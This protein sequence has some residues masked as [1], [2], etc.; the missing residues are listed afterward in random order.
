MKLSYPVPLP[1][2]WPAAFLSGAAAL[3]YEIVWTR[4]LSL[5]MGSTT[6]AAA[7]VLSAFML[8]LAAG[9]VLV[10]S[11]ADSSRRPLRWYALLEIGIG[12]YAL[13]FPTLLD[14][15]GSSWLMGCALVALPAALMGATLPVLT[16]AA[17][18]TTERGTG[19]FGSLYGINTLGAVAGAALTTLVF[20]ETLG[21][22][23]STQLAAFL[24]IGLGVLFYVFDLR[25]GRRE[26]FADVETPRWT[27]DAEKSVVAAFFV[28]GFAGLGLEIAWV[29]TLVYFLEGFTIAFGLMLATY[30]LGLGAG[31]MGGTWLA[32]RS[33]NPRRLLGRILL[34]QG[35][36]SLLTFLLVQ[37]LG[38]ALETMR[39]RYTTAAGIDGGYAM[40]LFWAALA[41][42]LPSTL[43]AGALMP[44]V[45]RIALAD[46]ESIGRQTGVVYAASTLG[47]VIAPPV[48]GFW[49]IPAVGVPGTIALMAA[50]LLFVGT[51][52]A[53]KRGLKEW[54]VAGAGA[55]A[56][57]AVFLVADIE[58][59]L[60]KRSHVFRAS[61]TPRRLVAFEEGLV[62]GVS[63]VEE[64]KNGARRL[65]IDGFSAAETGR[66]YGYM[67]MLGH[68]PVLLHENPERVCVIAFGT[69]TTAG[70]ATLHEEVSRVVCVEIEPRVYDVAPA[71]TQ[72]NRDV[73]NSPKVEAIVADGREYVRRGEEA[74]DVITLEPLMPYT[75]G[76]VY[77]YTKEFYEA[78]RR[79][80]R[81]KG[82]LCQWFPPQGVSNAD[83]KRLIASMT[84]VFRHV[85]LWYFEH[86]VLA[87]GG[88]FAPVIDNIKFAARCARR[89]VFADLL[90]V[91]GSLDHLL[92][93][94][95]CSGEALR[96]AL[97]D[98][99]PFVDDRTDLEFRPL[100]RRFGKRMMTYHA[101]NME[102]LAT[103]HQQDVP[104]LK[105]SEPAVTMLRGRLRANMGAALDTLAVEKRRETK[106][107]V[108]PVSASVLRD[109]AERDPRSR[110]VQSIYQ[111][112]LYV[113]LWRQGEFARA[114]ALSHAPDR[115]RAFLALA[116]EAEEE[117][118]DDQAMFYRLLALREN[119]LLEPELLKEMA[120]RFGGPQK[121]FLLNRARVQESQPVDPGAEARPHPAPPDLTPALEAQDGE[122][123]A[124]TLQMARSAGLGKRME[125]VC[126]QWWEQQADQRRAAL[127]LYRIGS[128]KALWAA[129]RMR[130]DDDKI[131]LAVI[132][133]ANYPR[134]RDWERLCSDRK[135]RVKEAAADAAATLAHADQAH[136][137]LRPIGPLLNHD[138]EGVRL[139]AYLAFRAIHPDAEAAGYNHLK[140]NPKAIAILI[141]LANGKAAAVDNGK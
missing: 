31:A 104:W 95:I 36:L 130:S 35:V 78:A 79:S 37:P 114:A 40:G 122:A 135:S 42:I 85:S 49:I 96:K 120:I 1:L 99:E 18:D 105:D 54:A 44:V 68:L 138:D 121:R 126:G 137:F 109:V 39:G 9:A 15:A 58:T 133:A 32:L 94:H 43:C 106:R 16:R 26:I 77:L 100:P 129:R 74:F 93:S 127:F 34:L 101:E 70:A 59:P 117:A 75:P 134:F 116:E 60:V 62:G 27:G 57:V 13:A 21:L 28:A 128:D 112:R 65:Y 5:T 61:K 51:W 87:V 140:P 17:A 19:A 73:L 56:F 46:R 131:A 2:L 123:A 38:D 12:A 90:A 23:G 92:A 110:F 86:A 8:G 132:F 55:A 115:S 25:V 113:E 30:L 10:G 124:A 33:P 29:R 108:E 52:L 119:A 141:G 103:H 50:L 97:G 47:A 20:L 98:A 4:H 63:V 102:F 83:M 88:D 111:R 67:R 72:A 81:R 7:A 91:V 76:A 24:N 3:V 6:G 14:M 139:S 84:S 22:S 80:L 48:A 41:V 82:L 66:H 118:D 136:A 53:L 71:F 69:G 89:E 11:A 107:V 125:T 64:Y 45:A